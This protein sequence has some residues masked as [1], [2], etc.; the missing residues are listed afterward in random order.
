ML[1][2]GKSACAAWLCCMTL[3]VLANADDHLTIKTDKGKIHGKLSDDGQV[4]A[5][6]GVPYSAPPVGLLR[7]KPPQASIKWSGV[8]ETTSFGFRCMQPDI[9]H[10]MH[11]RDS[12]ESEDCLTLNVW[13]PAKDKHAKLPVMVWIYGGGFVAGATSE[14]RQDG[15][16]LAHKGVVVVSMNYRL[17]LFGFFVHP[18]LAAESP[19]HSA[20]NYGLM[21]QTAA[22]EWVKRNVSAFGGDPNNV[23]LFGESAGSFSVSAQM[24]SPLAQGLFAHAIG[25]SG[26]AFYSRG[27]SFASLEEREKNDPAFAMSVFGT[28][29]LAPLRAM[30][31]QD[32][33]QKMATQANP[34]RPGVGP[35][36]DGYFLPEP[37]PQ[38]YK[39][40][41]QAH[42]SL[43]AGWNRDEPSALAVN[44]PQSPTV[45]SFQQ[46]AQKSFG[47]RAQDF[48]RVYSA[49]TD[50]E[51]M[52]SAIDFAGDSFIAFSTW[53]WLEA[54]IATG[55]APVY[56]YHFERPAPAD[57]YHPAGS[58]AFHSDEIEY[59]FGTLNARPDAVWQPEDQKLSDLVETYW[60]N[61]ART[62][63]PNG[64]GA[65]EWPQSNAGNDWQL[66]HLDVNSQAGP[67]QHRDRYLFLQN[68]WAKT[69]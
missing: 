43:L 27:L 32:M 37:V 38:I 64:A 18:G 10:D 61:F 8:R 6:L 26:A 1:S 36:V 30:S 41:K 23:T 51:A 40:G 50:A 3:S 16:H 54:Q 21:D 69:D 66:M 15:E 31:A 46:T 62:G 67:D 7:W 58:G 12:G 13:T 25:E 59:V 39:E 28:S 9:F 68:V 22:L 34:G 19:Q 2:R 11:F 60:T 42:I 53:Q 63:N 65:P 33:M 47:D 52:R 49:Q 29:D 56:R 20:G 57:K 55:A 45:Q 14:P 17:G 44:F 35:D 24:A 4:R 48:L 5:F